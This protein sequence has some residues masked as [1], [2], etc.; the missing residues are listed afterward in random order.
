LSWRT[1]PGARA[2]VEVAGWPSSPGPAGGGVWAKQTPED[3]TTAASDV[4]TA[5]ELFILTRLLSPLRRRLAPARATLPGKATYH[6]GVA[7]AAAGKDGAM[8]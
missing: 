8:M 5:I 7:G 3:N 4:K 2:R 6:Y 1:R